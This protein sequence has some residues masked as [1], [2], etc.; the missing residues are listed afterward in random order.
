M[1]LLVNSTDGVWEALMAESVHNDI[2]DSFHQFPGLIFDLHRFEHVGEL[3][4]TQDAFLSGKPRQG[5]QA[6]R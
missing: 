5:R 3:L 2:G 1:A 6:H 4:V